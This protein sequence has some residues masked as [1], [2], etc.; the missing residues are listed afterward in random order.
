MF[1]ARL[2]SIINVPSPT[3]MRKLKNV[4]VTKGRSSFGYSLRPFISPLVSWNAMKLNMPGMVSFSTALHSLVESGITSRH[5]PAFLFV[6]QI[7]S[8][9]ANLD[10]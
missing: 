9:A 7:D 6:S 8:I 5:I 1:P 3:I 10:G 2:A 4:G